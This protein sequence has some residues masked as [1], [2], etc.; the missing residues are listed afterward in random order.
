MLLSQPQE[1]QPNTVE[2]VKDGSVEYTIT[3]QIKV[4]ARRQL[5]VI[6]MKSLY[7]RN[8]PISRPLLVLMR[9]DWTKTG[10]F[11]SSS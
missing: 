9:N 7:K 3:G 10:Y 1:D 6:G 8:E 11:N 4:S 5:I 2:V